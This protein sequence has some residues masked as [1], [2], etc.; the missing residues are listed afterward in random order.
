M[1][2]LVMYMSYTP[3]LLCM[4]VQIKWFCVHEICCMKNYN[5][6]S[7]VYYFT[8]TF[9]YFFLTH[10]C[11]I[12]VLAFVL[13][14]ISNFLLS[15]VDFLIFPLTCFFYLDLLMFSTFFSFTP[16]SYSF[17]ELHSTLSEKKIFVTN[18]PILTDSPKPPSS[19]P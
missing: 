8:I 7:C 4:D 18:F 12:F 10:L 6:W 11:S 1:L 16:I 14:V 17:L 3:T 9:L 13:F 15:S 5:L 19:P 2:L